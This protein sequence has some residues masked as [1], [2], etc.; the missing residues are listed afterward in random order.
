MTQLGFYFFMV[1]LSYGAAQLRVLVDPRKRGEIAGLAAQIGLA[2][3]ALS[4]LGYG[5]GR[6]A[7]IE[8]AES[9]PPADRELVFAHAYA[10]P[11]ASLARDLDELR[12]VHA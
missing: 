5:E 10:E 1:A 8:A 9:E 12:R 6:V 2:E 11:P 7:A 4:G 3:A